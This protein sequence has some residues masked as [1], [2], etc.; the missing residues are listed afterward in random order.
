MSLEIPVA[1]PALSKYCETF[2]KKVPSGDYWWA[3]VELKNLTLV[4]MPVQILEIIARF[5]IN[6]VCLLYFWLLF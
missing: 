1:S 3:A 5:V 4:E 6:I 2:S